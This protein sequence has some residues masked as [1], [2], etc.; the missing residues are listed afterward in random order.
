MLRDLFSTGQV[1]RNV[2]NERVDPE[3]G[4]KMSLRQN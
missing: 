4:S 1:L 2:R 3:L